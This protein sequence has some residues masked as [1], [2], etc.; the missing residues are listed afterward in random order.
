MKKKQNQSL[1]TL[2]QELIR[3]ILLR[4]PVKSLLRFKC[5]C[6]SFLSL[7]S[8]PQFVISHY[9]LAA[10]PTHRLILRSHDFYAQSIATESV[11]KTC[12]RDVVYFPLPLPSIPCL[13]L[14]DFGIRPK[15]LGS[16]RGL[17]LLYY[18]D[19][20]NLILWNPSLGRHKRLP[21]YRDDITSFHSW[22]N[23][24]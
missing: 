20:A 16:C 2:P 15:I 9:A 4:L 13:R 17:V 3:E 18:V 1:T 6:K 24:H 21:N 8:D 12:S 23:T 11:F 5:V 22:S 7:I 14:D 10:S 19:S